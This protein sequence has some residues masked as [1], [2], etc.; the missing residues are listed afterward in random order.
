MEL[1]GRIALG[2]PVAMLVLVAATQ[3]VGVARIAADPA[4]PVGP[5][6]GLAASP[7][8]RVPAAEVTWYRLDPV[9]DGTGT[10]AGQRLIA[11]VGSAAP[12]VLDLPAE[13]F[14]SGPVGG[15]VLLGDDDGLRSRMRWLD[16]GRRCWTEAAVE[17]A[18]IR[19]AVA[20]PDG[21]V[22]FEHRVDR[23][24]RADLGVWRR[25]IAGPA[26][27]VAVRV[28]DALV[29]DAATGPTFS[30]DL[31]VA[32]D[33]RLIEASCGE[34]TCRTRVLDQRTGAVASASGTGPALGVSG[35]RLVAMAACETL[36]CAVEAR[37]LTDGSVARLVD[38]AGP[39]LLGGPGDAFLV[40]PV[41]GAV[42][43]ETVAGA[44][45]SSIPTTLLPVLRGSTAT[46]GAD[47]PPGTVALAP[48]GRIAD[49]ASAF[50]LDPQTRAVSRLLEV[51]P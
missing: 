48:G 6:R 51:N 4:P 30:T 18:V 33:G 35:R 32:A 39:G 3:P 31:S 49:P 41:A 19:G 36:P 10:L 45:A 15:A 46:S 8:V 43:V 11:A 26:A 5:C 22:T 1:G 16:V 29:P 21:S 37:D 25:T 27:E 17:A 13:S 28:L 44:A 50:R 40:V 12:V 38:E 20:S 47:T 34:L 42:E 24:T 9:L 2:L 14:A 23:R 7:H